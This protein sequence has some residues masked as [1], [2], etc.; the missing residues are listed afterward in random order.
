MYKTKGAPFLTRVRV[1]SD[2]V[3]VDDVFILVV[4]V[5][6]VVLVDHVLRRPRPHVLHEDGRVDEP[7]TTHVP[8]MIIL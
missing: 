2:Q 1:G 4:V 5:V 7:P 8:V 6:V 3:A